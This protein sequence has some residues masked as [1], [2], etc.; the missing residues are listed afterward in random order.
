MSTDI[1]GGIFESDILTSYL[2][3][4][5][6]GLT[7]IVAAICPMLATILL[8]IGVDSVEL[9]INVLSRMS[10]DRIK[11]FVKQ[12]LMTIRYQKRFVCSLQ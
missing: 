6:V 11:F 3:I 10:N 8:G 1:A 2:V 7:I 4:A 9:R 12:W 5:A